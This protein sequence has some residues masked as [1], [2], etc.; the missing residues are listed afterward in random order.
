MIQEDG[1]SALV[2]FTALDSF[3][4]SDLSNSTHSSLLS[5]AEFSASQPLFGELSC[6]R[7]DSTKMPVLF[8]RDNQNR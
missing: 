1:D 2:N 8:S 6:Y 3:D 5:S 4:S 7:C